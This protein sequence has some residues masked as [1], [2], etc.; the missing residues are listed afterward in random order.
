[1]LDEESLGRY[2]FPLFPQPESMDE[3]LTKKR[4]ITIAVNTQFT[5]QIFLNMTATQTKK[6]PEYT[7]PP[8]FLIFF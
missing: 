8:L 5:Q 2:K 6:E 3:T 1:V 7:H 4:K